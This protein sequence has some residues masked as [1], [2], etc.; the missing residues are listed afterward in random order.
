MDQAR[1]GLA[2]QGNQPRKTD[3]IAQ[4]GGVSNTQIHDVAVCLPDSVA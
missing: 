3:G 4:L 2:D 1:P